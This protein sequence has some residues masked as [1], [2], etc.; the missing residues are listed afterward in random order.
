MEVEAQDDGVMAKILAEAGTK[1][2]PV[3]SPIA[4]I[5]EEGDDLSGA[6]AL[7]EEA[8]KESSAAEKS[9]EQPKQEEPKQEAAPPKQEQPKDEKPAPPKQESKTGGTETGPLSRVLST[10]AARRLALERG[11]PLLQI[12]GSGPEGRVLK[13]DVEKYTPAAA[14]GAAPAAAAAA[15][16]APGAA[17]PTYEDI[18]LSNMRRTIAKRLSESKSTVPHYYV[19]VSYTHLTLPTKRIV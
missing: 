5:G 1:N 13:E 17:A 16:A 14:G 8:T 9:E 12:K 2:V 6:D 11:V 18:P 10:P 19:S 4:I 15:P 7:A 3:N